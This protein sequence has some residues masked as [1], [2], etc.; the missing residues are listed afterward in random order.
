M[1]YTFKHVTLF[2]IMASL[3]FTG[4]SC[5]QSSDPQRSPLPVTIEW[6]TVFKN[7]SDITPLISAYEAAHPHV[8]VVVK[9]I[10]FEDFKDDLLDALAEDR[11][12]DIFTIHNT[13][14]EQ[15]KS[16]ISAMPATT[17]LE[18]AYQKGTLSKKVYSRKVA[19]PSFTPRYIN[20]TFLDQVVKDLYQQNQFW[21]VPLSVDT[22]ALYYNKALLAAAGISLPATNYATLQ[23]HVLKLTKQSATGTLTQSGVA[24]GTANNVERYQDILSLLMMQNGTEMTNDNGT[25]TFQAMPESLG[26]RETLP[27]ADALGFYSDFASPTK[28]VYTWNESRPN[29]LEAFMAGSVGYLFGYAYHLPTIK[30]QAPKLNLGIAKA[31]QITGNTEVNFANYWVEVVSNKSKNSDVA[32]NFLQF[33]SQPENVKL[34]LEQAK[35]PTATKTLIDAQKEDVEIGVFAEQLLTA[36][37]WYQG[38][39]PQVV[40]ETFAQMINEYKLG[41]LDVDEILSKAASRINQSRR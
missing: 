32:W 25:P 24:M 7:T 15:Y 39:N 23:E 14:I 22:L 8:N 1:K 34:Y 12:P 37:S 2:A 21:G 13:E 3:I 4:A 10:R 19:T 5:S 35:L 16:K 28:Q 33:I 18:E 11:G 17:T 40:D 38:K 27:A 30:A 6:W 31:P 36:K 9:N 20:Q 29:S 41:T 26:R